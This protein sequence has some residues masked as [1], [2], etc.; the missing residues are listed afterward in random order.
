MVDESRTPSDESTTV[1]G[2]LPCAKKQRK[3]EFS[4]SDSALQHSTVNTSGASSEVASAQASAGAMSAAPISIKVLWCVGSFGSSGRTCAPT[5]PGLASR[6]MVRE[7]CF[8]EILIA[9]WMTQS[10]LLSRSIQTIKFIVVM[11]GLARAN[12]ERINSI[13][14]VGRAGGVISSSIPLRR[15]RA[16]ARRMPA[17][18]SRRNNSGTT[19]RACS[20][21]FRESA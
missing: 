10:R 13:S 21:T 5:R 4:L 6:M 11:C 20:A 9:R 3:A 1:T 18:A 15:R 17:L 19:R 8:S 16:S 2:R 7:G 12:S 14:A